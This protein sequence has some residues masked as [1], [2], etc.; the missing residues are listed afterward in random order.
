MPYISHYAERTEVLGPGVRFAVWLQ[1]CAKRCPGCINPEGQAIGGGEYLS[2]DV[3]MQKICAVPNLTG[4]TISGG[5]PFLQAEE[6]KQLIVRIKE[7][8]SLD[9]MLYSGYRFEE[10]TAQYGSEFFE[11]V[12]IFIDGEYI[13]SLNHNNMYRGSDNQRMFF[14]T[15][16]YRQ[17][18]QDW[19]QATKRD[20]A[21]EYTEK[22]GLIFI[23]IPPKDFYTALLAKL[24]ER[25][26]L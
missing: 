25:R 8:T 19:L 20:I 13:E 5:E 7:E 9:I 17:Y 4:V 22:N 11:Q 3:L 2:V 26:T 12:D 14:F 16:K 6:L 1:G 18:A 21:F 23:G 24:A 15:P 10:L